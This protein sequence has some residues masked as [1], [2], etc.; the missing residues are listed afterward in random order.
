MLPAPDLTQYLTHV[1]P[2]LLASGC[3]LLLDEVDQLV[4]D[5]NCVLEF[6]AGAGM[7][8]EKLRER[9]LYANATL[10]VCD[11]D[12]TLL[13]YVKSKKKHPLRVSA[14][15]R[16][17]PFP[18]ASFHCA[19]GNAY[20]LDEE[21]TQSLLRSLHRVIT[22]AG[23]CII[24]GFL[25]G[26]FDELFDLAA[27]AAEMKEDDA[28]QQRIVAQQESLLDHAGLIALAEK[29]GFV[30][31]KAGICER[32]LFLADGDA[33]LHDPLATDLLAP[34]WLGT[35]T[36]RPPQPAERRRILEAVKESIDTYF[37]AQRFSLRLVTGV[38]VATRSL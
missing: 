5:E 18:D 26:S 25:K 16:N 24:A 13:R 15:A 36:D 7:L 37:G 27:E 29:E 8:T 20:F 1:G 34:L 14:A 6:N 19:M 23:K 17:L 35:P 4:L 38:V 11:K 28:R 30:G 31:V 12:P 10:W 33:L 32:A 22:P 3:E 21:Y 2:R 9:T